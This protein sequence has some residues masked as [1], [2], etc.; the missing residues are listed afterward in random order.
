TL[1][2]QGTAEQPILFTSIKDPNDPENP[3][4]R[5]DW[6]QIHLTDYAENAEPD[7]FG[8]YTGCVLNH[9]IVE[10]A[11]Q[12]N[13]PALFVEKCSPMITNCTF[14]HN[15]A[16]GITVDGS[17]SPGVNISGCIVRDHPSRGIVISNGSGHNINGCTIYDNVGGLE[18]NNAPADIVNGNTVYDNTVA[19]NGAGIYLNN[20]DNSTVTNNTVTNNYSTNANGGGICFSNSANCTITG[21]TLTGN[22][23]Y[24]HGG[25]LYTNN[26]GN[27]LE[28]NTIQSNTAVHY[29]GG[30]LYLTGGS[31]TLTENTISENIA[32][33]G[34][35]LGGGMYL[36]GHG[37][38]L[39]ANQIT[40]NISNKNGGGIY[41]SNNNHTIIGN[42]ITGNTTNQN[43]GGIYNSRGTG[44]IF[45]SNT[46]SDNSSQLNGGGLFADR[47]HNA[48]F[49]GDS[50][51]RNAISAEGGAI[52]LTD[53]DN[54]TFS[55]T[56]IA[57]NTTTDGLT[58]G[59][60][61]TGSSANLSF[62]GDTDLELYNSILT[63][64]GYWIY[65]NNPFMGDGQNDVDA[66]DVIWG[67]EDAAV[68]QAALYD[69]FDD[70]C[71][72]FVVSNPLFPAQGPILTDTVWTMAGGPYH[73][74]DTVVVGNGATL[75]ID[76]GVDIFMDDMKGII[77]GSDAYGIG[78]L[79]AQGTE[80]DPIFCTTINDPNDLIK[81]A[82]PGDWSRI[83]FTDYA[84]DAIETDPNVFEGSILEHVI[85]EYAGRCG[86]AAVFLDKS[87]PLIKG[88][89]IR[90]NSAIGITVDGVVNFPVS[91]LDTH[92]WENAGRGI[93]I[94][95][96]SDHAVHGCTVNDNAGG[97]RFTNAPSDQVSDNQVYDNTVAENGAGIYFNNADNSTV[98]NNTVSNNYST[99]ANG[100]GICFSNSANCTITGNTLAG[101]RTYYHGGGLYTNNGG[102]LIEDNTIHNN[103]AIH[104]YGGGFYATGGGT[105]IKDN[106][107]SENN[108]PGGSGLGG[109][110]YLAGH[111]NSLNT[112]QII[113]NISNKS[114][115]GIYLANNTHTL[116]NNT[117][118]GNVSNENGGGVYNSR[119]TGL[120]FTNNTITDNQAYGS[121][122]G[123]G[124]LFADRGHS[125]TF[126]LTVFR[127]NF[128]TREGGG[129]YLTDCDNN[130]FTSSTI[131]LNRTGVGST[132]GLFVA[133]SCSNLSLAG[134]PEAGT[135]N[136]I[137]GN[138]EY[139]IY[140]NNDR[141]AMAGESTIQAGFVQWGTNDDSIINVRLY[142]FFDNSTRGFIMYPPIILP[143]DFDQDGDVDF[144][145]FTL[146]MAHWL[147]Q[148]CVQPD[149]CSGADMDADG[150][151]DLEDF[152]IF[153]IVY[154]P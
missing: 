71:K 133:G 18:I 16:T 30:G 144:V 123:G 62:A 44:L 115:G 50:I 87:S 70:S 134:D 89:D 95:N 107:I 41:L 113:D 152:A 88:C 84:V 34:S 154:A 61:V 5:G 28:N 11:G 64:D 148:D 92:V 86:Y 135:Y 31:T 48:T 1:V 96:G 59:V 12:S 112:N 125:C 139:W 3:A 8:G 42:T 74:I 79:V 25:G 122:G 85:V 24:Y 116:S 27:N 39:T 55:L 76:P 73:I 121:G 142:D 19:Q 90:R 98:T 32:N 143:A 36:A 119:G 104:Y 110:I 13:L 145:D 52:Y 102:N 149:W 150:D 97:I 26:G 23:T 15:K 91:I 69:C 37:N 131:S 56:T 4:Q 137:V 6:V 22:S 101:N 153:A 68:L 127:G 129:I 105:T 49:T 51:E 138:E 29:Y 109:G 111:T 147:R 14:R 100:G 72:A 117:I 45:T 124:G 130:V 67:T 60:F 58:G 126:D 151:V 66:S 2:A 83:H 128:A 47:G 146:F 10:Y 63:N 17:S 94:A 21:N 77:V 82:A 65:N 46:I 120:S 99:N 54:N 40:D 103:Q 33:G 106:T 38:T 43:G 108:A 9:V 114:G 57:D 141:L 81:P 75:T 93:S 53:C 78:T 35:G 80:I 140:N 7:G 20:A 132:G 118:S 136:T